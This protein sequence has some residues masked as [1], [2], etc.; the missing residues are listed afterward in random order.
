MCVRLPV[1][2]FWSV[3][4]SLTLILFSGAQGAA[5]QRQ[6]GP[7]APTAPRPDNPRSLRHIDAARQLAGSDPFLENPFDF[8]CVAGNARGNNVNAPELE[9]MKIFDNVYA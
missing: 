3:A 1:A 4:I 2:G 8:F 6:G 9:P 7:P 5:I